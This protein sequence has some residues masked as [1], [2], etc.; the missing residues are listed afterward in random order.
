[1]EDEDLTECVIID[2]GASTDLFCRKDKLQNV[3]KASTPVTLTTNAGTITVDEEGDYPGYGVVPVHED[4]VTNIF[5]LAKLAK[6]F[7]VTYDSAKEDVILVHTPD[8]IKRFVR[9]NTGLYV[10]RPEA[11]SSAKML[12]HVQTVEENMQFH[13]PREVQ[14]AKKAR[15]LL[16]SLGSPSV[17]DLKK[18]ISTNAIANLPVTT[19][20]VVLAE[21]IFGKDIGIIKGKTTRRRPVPRVKDQLT[22]PPELY[23]RI[24]LEMCMDIMFVN[25]IPYLTTIT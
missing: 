23:E 13:T 2:S 16:V 24:S 8:G 12:V 6:K 5:A 18:A 19:K 15:E 9:H 14:R 1:M 20:D 10:H 21:K 4:A 17:E 22:I 7:R 25:E 3:R 11:P